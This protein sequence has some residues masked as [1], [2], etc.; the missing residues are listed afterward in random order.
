MMNCIL[1]NDKRKQK[2]NNLE[3]E[4]NLQRDRKNARNNLK[5]L[6][7][8]TTESGKSTFFKQMRTIYGVPWSEEDKRTHTRLA[9]QGVL[10]AM[11]SLLRA[12]DQLGIEFGKNWAD[13]Q[14]KAEAVKKEGEWNTVT[15]G[16]NT[17]SD[18]DMVLSL[19]RDLWEDPGIQECYS[20]RDEY[21]ISDADLHYLDNLH[22]LTQPGYLPVYEDI[23]NSKPV[24]KQAVCEFLFIVDKA[25]VFRMIDVCGQQRSER[26][27]WIRC[28]EDATAIL[29]FVALSDYDRVDGDNLNRLEASKELFRTVI[30]YPWFW[31]AYFIL[32][33]NKKDLLAEKIFHSHLANHFPE[34]DGPQG[35]HIAARE[36]IRKMFV[37]LKPPG[38]DTKLYSHFI[39]AIDTEDIRC[40]FAIVRD[41]IRYTNLKGYQLV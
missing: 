15:S 26:R 22:R 18:W 7:L 21:Q 39:C 40:V 29:F 31:N 41:E 34:Y 30:T 32:L 2:R 4:K 37:D 35:D 16:W 6:L 1:R 13:S 19:I 20:R 38:I 33:L 24:I 17:V 11:Q 36:F 9:R 14:E 23:F 10:W 5:L 8:G 27:K 28:F 25:N 3:I 12:P